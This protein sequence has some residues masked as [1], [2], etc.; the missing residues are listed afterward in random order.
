M[1]KSF[2]ILLV[3]I[4]SATAIVFLNINKKSDSNMVI[5]ENITNLNPPVDVMSLALID[6]TMFAGGRDGVYEIKGSF[7]AYEVRKLEFEF[8]VEYVRA[9]L[10]DNRGNLWIGYNNGLIKY[11]VKTGEY[12]HISDNKGELLDKRVN[13][14]YMDSKNRIWVGTWGGA[15]CYSEGK[16]SY[17]TTENGLINNMV[18]VI[19]E[20]KIGSIWFCS[21]DVKDGGVSILDSNSWQYINTENGLPNINVTAIMQESN[22]N[23]WVGTGFYDK[24]GAAIFSFDGQK[25]VLLKQLNLEDG[26]AGA[27]VRSLFENN[28]MIFLGSE[29]NGFTVIKDESFYKINK[30]N[31]I[32]NDEIKCILK[33]KNNLIWLGTREG[34]SI[35]KE[36]FIEEI[37]NN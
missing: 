19:F 1:K 28:E 10:I 18:N 36:D 23:I 35:F 24:G 31:G 2:I 25:Y 12:I 4:L 37:L 21:Y 13:S 7:P 17:Y 9:I 3:F 8:K 20:D 34:I 27:K 16:W 26:L 33:D 22:D 29:Y 14:L 32:V 6:D 5:N 15:A 30:K 11:T